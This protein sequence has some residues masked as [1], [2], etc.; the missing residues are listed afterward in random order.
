MKKLYLMIIS[1]L[2]LFSV[3]AYASG[4]SIVDEVN[5]LTR[6][7]GMEVSQMLQNIKDTYNIDAAIVI[8]NSLDGKTAE[9]YADDYYD[10]NGY[11]MGENDD[12]LLLL[13]SKNPRKYHITTHALAVKMFDDEA[14]DYMAVSIENYLRNDDYYSAC[15]TFAEKTEE[16]ANAYINGE[17]DE[18]YTADDDE[19]YSMIF[20]AFFVAA[21]V[22]AIMTVSAYKNMNTARTP[23]NANLYIKNGSMNVK[24]AKDI[25]LYRNVTKTKIESS[26]SSSSGGSRT[27]RSSSGRSHGGRGGSY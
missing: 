8:V 26:S 14:L 12:G 19:F 5:Y 4:A 11:G 15:V 16:I 1:M 21:I 23:I 20:C 25:F 9:G 17:S 18:E 10:Y 13:I 22:A 6:E 3:T 24:T 2:F 7:E 27:H